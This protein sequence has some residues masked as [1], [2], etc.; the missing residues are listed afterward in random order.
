MSV[1]TV[2]RLLFILPFSRGRDEDR[3]LYVCVQPVQQ[4]WDPYRCR[5]VSVPGSSMWVSPCAQLCL[6]VKF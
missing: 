6:A 5:H 3:S 2:A 4:P 1:L